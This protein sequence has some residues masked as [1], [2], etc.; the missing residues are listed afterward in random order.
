MN[1]AMRVQPRLILGLLLTALPW[2]RLAVAI[3]GA[4]ETMV[5]LALAK[6][7]IRLHETMQR[8]SPGGFVTVPRIR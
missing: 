5:D 3:T 8:R 6:V 7:L 1:Q 2:C 4:L